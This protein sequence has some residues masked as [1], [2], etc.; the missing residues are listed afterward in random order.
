MSTSHPSPAADAL[1]IFGITGDLAYKMTLPALYALESRGVLHG[2]VIGVASRD[3][4]H[5]DLL[6]RARESVRRARPDADRAVLERLL[7]RLRYVGG[8]VTN[9]PDVY[10]QIESELGRARRPLYY[11]ETPPTL[12]APIVERLDAAGL[13]GDARVAL[14]KP[15][16]TDLHS[17]TELGDRL[18]QIVPDDRLLLVDHFL[19]KEPVIEIEYLRFAN[20]AIAEIWDRTTVE[21]VQITMAEDFG[22]EGRGSFYD[23]VGAARDVVQNHLLQVLALV[24]MDAPVGASADELKARKL[25][26]LKAIPPVDTGQVVRGQYDGYREIPGVAPDSDVETFVALRLAIDSWRWAGVPVFVRAGKR[27]PVTGTEVRLV[28]RETPRLRFLPDAARVE[29]NQVVLRI[30]PQ[31]GLRLQL[32][33]LDGRGA[34]KPVRL[35][36]LFEHDLGTPRSPYERLLEDALAGDDRLFVREDAIAESWRI[37]EPLLRYPPPVQPYRPGTWGPDAAASLLDG[38]PGWHLPWLPDRG[39]ER[40]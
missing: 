2:P 1:V 4:T 35:D 24:A 26:V 38:H 27:M 28:L 8:D 34:W 32:S 22:V 16:G 19:G 7:G 13:L 18:R 12:F 31:P 33:G 17:A 15:F 5:A 6:E 14:E 10:K 30:S 3:L 25:E 39:E 36:S 23:S 40:P 37:L 20:T 29:A 21:A 9:D 11:L